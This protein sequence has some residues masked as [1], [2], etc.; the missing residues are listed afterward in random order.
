VWAVLDGEGV[1]AA[2][3]VEFAVRNPGA[4][5]LIEHE[6][7]TAGVLDLEVPDGVTGHAICFTPGLADG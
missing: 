4:Y 1:V 6:R 2:N 3:G 7:H 5:P